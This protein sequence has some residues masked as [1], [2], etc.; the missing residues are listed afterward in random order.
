[1]A[2]SHPAAQ[3]RRALR[4]RAAP[5]QDIRRRAHRDA[6]RPRARAGLPDRRHPRRAAGEHRRGL[7][8]RPRLV[9]PPRPLGGRGAGPR[10]LRRSSSPRFPT[11]AEVA[12]DREDRRAAARARSCRC[13]TTCATSGPTTSASSSSRRAAT[14][15]AGA[16]DGVAVPAHRS[17]DAHPAQHQRPRKGV[18]PKVMSL[19]EVLNAWLDAPP[20][21]AGAPHRASGSSR[22]PPARG[23]RRLPDRL[24]QPRRG[25]PHHPRRGRAEAG[26]DEDLQADRRSG[27]GDPQ[28]AAPQRCASSRRSRSAPSTTS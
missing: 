25:D 17:R 24:P 8:D 13:S 5:D 2:T 6:G 28:H 11:G 16:A 21:G 1:M 10:H 26:A 7:P 27:R 23:A 18:V 12:P 15:D 3:R 14:V 4:R 19:G 20:R 22:S 9:P